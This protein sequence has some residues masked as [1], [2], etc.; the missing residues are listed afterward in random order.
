[1]N[2]LR[3][4]FHWEKPLPT[5][6]ILGCRVKRF[7]SKYFAYCEPG[8]VTL[9]IFRNKTGDLNAGVIMDTDDDFVT[10][11]RRY[12]GHQDV[13]GTDSSLVPVDHNS[14][15]TYTVDG[16]VSTRRMKET[17]AFMEGTLRSYEKRG[18]HVR[19]LFPLVS[20]SDPFYE[21]YLLEG[22]R[23]DSVWLF[24]VIGKELDDHPHWVYD[25]PHHSIP[26]GAQARI[27]DPARWLA[28]IPALSNGK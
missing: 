21:V 2:G 28:S 8:A 14:I 3:W 7:G 13:K 1:M 18:H 26:D 16:A 24:R 6:S 17:T 9:D 15:T 23:V 12:T 11:L 25:I 5:A 4:Y 20:G 27:K 10:A 19:C 22:E